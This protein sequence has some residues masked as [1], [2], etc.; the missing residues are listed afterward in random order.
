MYV[1]SINMVAALEPLIYVCIIQCNLSIAAT[2]GGKK[3]GRYVGV[4][5][6]CFVH[7][8]F[9]WDLDSWPLYRGGLYIQGWPLRGVP[10]TVVTPF[11][12]G[13]CILLFPVV[14]VQ[15]YALT[16]LAIRSKWLLPTQWSL[17]CYVLCMCKYSHNCQ[18]SY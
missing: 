1:Q 17:H 5:F 14:S 15:L 16:A 12:V 3:C 11:M 9:I 2:L 6:I 13:T 8:L 10:C 18:P 4:A 7:K